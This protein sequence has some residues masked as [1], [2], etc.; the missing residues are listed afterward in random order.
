MGKEDLGMGL[1]EV[2]AGPVFDESFN[3]VKRAVGA[4]RDVTGR[5]YLALLGWAASWR[6]CNLADHEAMAPILDGMHFP[7][8]TRIGKFGVAPLSIE[9]FIQTCYAKYYEIVQDYDGG[10]ML[11]QISKTFIEFC[12]E[13]ATCDE[14]QIDSVAAVLGSFCNM[15]PE[16]FL[17]MLEADQS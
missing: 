8:Y 7:I 5:H 4:Y 2:V 16:L 12:K 10:E 6:L 3:D 9:P 13:E 1:G 11:R 14:M 15:I 17:K